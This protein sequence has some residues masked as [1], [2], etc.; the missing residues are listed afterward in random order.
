MSDERTKGYLIMLAPKRVEK[1]SG[2]KE[3]PKLQNQQGEVGMELR[4]SY[5]SAKCKTRGEIQFT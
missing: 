4:G 1:I 2:Q 3:F 5:R